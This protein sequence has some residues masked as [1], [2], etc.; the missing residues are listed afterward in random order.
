MEQLSAYLTMI[1]LA[2]IKPDGQTVAYDSILNLFAAP[3]R[4]PAGLTDWDIAF[5]QGVY[6]AVQNQHS[7]DARLGAVAAAMARSVLDQQRTEPE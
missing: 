1:S 3:D 2:Q 6:G 5:L 7:G 4:A